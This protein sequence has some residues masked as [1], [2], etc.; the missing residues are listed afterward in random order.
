MVPLNKQFKG[1]K[2]LNL[3]TV[4]ETSDVQPY[5]T[6]NFMKVINTRDTY[7]NSPRSSVCKFESSQR[8]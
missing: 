8:F 2:G 4:L 7:M 1:K 6:K 3:S 5:S